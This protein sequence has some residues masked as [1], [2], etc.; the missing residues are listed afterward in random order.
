[1]RTLL[2]SAALC[3][4]VAGC[5]GEA[6]DRAPVPEQRP[7]AQQQATAPQAAQPVTGQ[8]PQPGA[9][10]L[11]QG[12]PASAAP[13]G[14]ALVCRP[15]AEVEETAVR[16][17]ELADANGDGKVSREEAQSLA[18]FVLGG[19]F[20]RADTNGDGT[21]TPEEGRQARAELMAQNPAI[22]SLLRSVRDATGRSPFATIARLTDVEYGESL[23]LAEARDAARTAVNDMLGLMDANKDNAITLPE[24]RNAAW[25]GTRAL[26]RAAF[27]A[28]DTDSDK[29]LNQDELQAAVR[30]SVE[31]AFSMADADKNGRLTEDEAAAAMGQL[32]RL[33]GIQVPA[34]N[35]GAAAK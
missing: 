27:R 28:A 9:A 1:M 23:T 34:A 21:V 18:N 12:S 8:P 26:G 24:A 22:A 2:L 6:G 17:L 15:G 33:V 20:F 5:R 14:D 35:R 16:L 3:A 11:A 7:G 4:F 32:N 30:S 19:F 31:V 29:S 10:G 25:E 13:A